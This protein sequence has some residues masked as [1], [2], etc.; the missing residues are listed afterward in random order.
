[1]Q[2]LEALISDA[3]C[4]DYP[5]ICIPWHNRR[6]DRNSKQTMSG[7]AGPDTA[8]PLGERRMRT[9]D[10]GEFQE[11]WSGVAQGTAAHALGGRT[12]RVSMR[13]YL[14]SNIHIFMA[15]LKN[16]RITRAPEDYV[17]LTI[18]L[19]GEFRVASRRKA[20]AY[21]SSSAHLLREDREFD[22]RAPNS[23]TVLV[24]NVNVQALES[25]R[26][27]LLRADSVEAPSHYGGSFSLSTP[28]GRSLWLL[29]SSAWRHLSNDNKIWN[30]QIAAQEWQDRILT[31][32]CLAY[33]HG[34]EDAG[35]RCQPKHL[36]RAVD[37]ILGNLSRPV[38]LADLSDAAGVSVY[39]LI[40]AFRKTYQITPIAFLRHRR[41]DAVH[42]LLLAAEPEDGT[43][44][45]AALRFGF[46]H[47]GRFAADYR[48][49][50]EEH[51]SDTLQANTGL[52]T[53]N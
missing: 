51:P 4:G 32:L 45:R 9:S 31:K 41:L 39:T 28:D 26:A 19:N 36:A 24:A 15:S 10:P 13:A 16:A 34:D 22:F 53:R 12:F 8:P 6:P 7:M 33:S 44:T 46:V 1:M 48:R 11:L 2:L 43:V 27:R 5:K 47:L 52:C 40:R 20:K 42:R 17:G 29:L 38:S 49:S 37:Y 3:L 50:F 25:H 30:N 18:P 23:S 35:H 14:L 21:A